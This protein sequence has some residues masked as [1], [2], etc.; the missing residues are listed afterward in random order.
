M[1]DARATAGRDD[2]KDADAT[3][4]TP[5]AP[6]APPSFE[7]P[8]SPAVNV[9][10]RTIYGEA[11][12][13]SVRGQEAIGAVVMN[14][15]HAAAAHPPHWWGNTVESIC[16]KP[17]QF[18]CWNKSDPNRRVIKAAKAGD[19]AFD[20]CLRIARRAVC[21][22]LADPTGGATH[23][24]VMGAWPPWARDRKPSAIIGRHVFYAGID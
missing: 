14:R 10:A 24:H 7:P 20:L 19:P 8:P 12:G 22:T 13:E 2:R 4:R 16:L 9:L 17:F 6:A 15:L 1:N 21:N 3:D 18:S 11:R 23:Y 5:A